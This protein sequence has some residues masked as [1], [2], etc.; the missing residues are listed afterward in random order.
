MFDYFPLTEP[1]VC[2]GR[3]TLAFESSLKF[4]PFDKMAD[5]FAI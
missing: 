2:R 3:A 4:E 1:E 5:V